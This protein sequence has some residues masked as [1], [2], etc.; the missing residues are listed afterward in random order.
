M[1]VYA[2]TKYTYV[3]VCIIACVYYV[4]LLFVCMYVFVYLHMSKHVHI[5]GLWVGVW[6]MSMF[7]CVPVF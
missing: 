6:F 4:L 7:V 5:K 3:P 2:Y 1:F